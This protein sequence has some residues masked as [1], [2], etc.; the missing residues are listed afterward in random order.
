MPTSHRNIERSG[1]S[2]SA[3]PATLLSSLF[4]ASIASLLVPY[5]FLFLVKQKSP[6]G[7]FHSFLN[8]VLNNLTGFQVKSEGFYDFTVLNSHANNI[9]GNIFCT[10][11]FFIRFLKEFS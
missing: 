7:L 10:E 9:I 5:A 1:T 2:V 8:M 3:S 6:E 11:D 4:S